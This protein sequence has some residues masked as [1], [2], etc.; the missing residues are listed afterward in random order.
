[1]IK[2]VLFMSLSVVDFNSVDY[3]VRRIEQFVLVATEVA[4]GVYGISF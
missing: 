3:C 4:L 2:N 1:M